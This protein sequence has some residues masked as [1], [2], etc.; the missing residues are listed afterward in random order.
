M[1]GTVPHV[2]IKNRVRETFV[3]RWTSRRQI[4][5][6]LRVD[7]HAQHRLVESELAELDLAMQ[8]RKKSH[9]HV[10]PLSLKKRWF[11]SRRALGSV[12]HNAIGFQAKVRPL[13]L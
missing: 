2:E 8:E 3:T 6:A 5:S 4:A 1:D 13:G 7:F 11:L 12:N 10:D 9:T